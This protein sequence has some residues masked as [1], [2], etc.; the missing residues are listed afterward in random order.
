LILPNTRSQFKYDDLQFAAIAVGWTT[1]LSYKAA[2]H[3]VV[4]P[5]LLSQVTDNKSLLKYIQEF[6]AIDSCTPAFY[7][8]VVVRHALLDAGI[9]DLDLT[10]YLA[11]LLL[12]FSRRDR[13]SKIDDHDDE[14]YQ[15]LATLRVDGLY[16]PQPIRKFK[17]HAHL[18]N[19]ALWKAGIF[20]EWLI[21]RGLS[22][23]YF[24]SMGQVGFKKAALN[25]V[26][27]RLSLSDVYERT[28]DNYL[29]IRK[30]L[31]KLSDSWS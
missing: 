17:L 30:A 24:D 9:D 22:F 4:N 7:L 27:K 6:P 14:I 21:K 3:L 13:A 29:C 1:D 10:D 8:Y 2:G 20:P 31:N 18:G 12:T 25:P 5:D 23:Q 19:Y 15:D 16:D 11:S 28:A 26:A